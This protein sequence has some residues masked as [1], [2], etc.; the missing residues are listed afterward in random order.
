MHFALRLINAQ[1]ASIHSIVGDVVRGPCDLD[2]KISAGE[3]NGRPM[4][5]HRYDMRGSDI[6]VH[7]LVLMR[8]AP[9]R[10]PSLYNPSVGLED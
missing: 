6:W 2:A 1:R 10:A 7:L 5:A 4:W 9:P 8:D 3:Q